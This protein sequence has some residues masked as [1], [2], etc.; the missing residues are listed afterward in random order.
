MHCKSH[1]KQLLSMV[2]ILIV[3]LLSGCPADDD[4]SSAKAGSAGS[5]GSGASAGSGASGAGGGSQSGQIDCGDS[6]CT[7][8]ETVCCYVDGVGSCVPDEGGDSC[9]VNG[10][11]GLVKASCDDASDCSAGQDCCHNSIGDETKVHKCA[12]LCDYAVVCN[13]SGSCPEGLTCL[14][15][16]GGGYTC[17]PDSS[18]SCGDSI[19]TGD[20]RYCAPDDTG[21]GQCVSFDAEVYPKYE[22]ASDGDCA[23]Y[24]CCF[25]TAGSACRAN[26]IEGY[27]IRPCST[28]NDCPDVSGATLVECAPL[29]DGPLAGVAS[30]CRYE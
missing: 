25:Y 3:P 4:D 14:E 15:A 18:I 2:S 26:C 20:T 22:C 10:A 24:G 16:D 19:C 8:G 23:P 17:Q 9:Q 6:V 12:A 27:D 30:T 21:A 5:S 13:S 7:V 1:V 11:Y 28:I 29:S